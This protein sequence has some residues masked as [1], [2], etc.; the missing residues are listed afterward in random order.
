[1][2]AIRFGRW[3]VYGDGRGARSD[4]VCGLV[5]YEGRGHAGPRPMAASFRTALMPTIV[6]VAAGDVVVGDR[7]YRTSS[8]YSSVSAA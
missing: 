3:Q 5:R 6:V 7:V 2:V 1:M 8:F 4:R